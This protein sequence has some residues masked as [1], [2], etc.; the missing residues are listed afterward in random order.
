MGDTIIDIDESMDFYNHLSNRSYNGYNYISDNKQEPVKHQLV[1]E[2]SE[3]KKK[4]LIK[5]QD[6]LLSA[7]FNNINISKKS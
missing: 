1:K 6:N 5:Q 3:N 7:Q 4:E 2:K